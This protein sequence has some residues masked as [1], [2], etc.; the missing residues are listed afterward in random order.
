MIE[1]NVI[2]IK[3]LKQVVNHGLALKTVHRVTQFN[4]K[5]WLKSYTDINT[6]LR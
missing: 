4:H 1:E 6:E 3:L 2:H 5:A